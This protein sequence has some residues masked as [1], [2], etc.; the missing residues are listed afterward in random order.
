M[1]SGKFLR[2]QNIPAMAE[3]GWPIIQLPDGYAGPVFKLDTTPALDTDSAW[4]KFQI[5]HKS[6]H[7]WHWR[8]G[9]E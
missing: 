8:T 1:K 5:P 4:A 9:A 7:S 3:F 6:F 2:I